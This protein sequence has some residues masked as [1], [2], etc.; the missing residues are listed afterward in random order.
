MKRSPHLW[1]VGCGLALM[2]A[3]LVAPASS[4]SAATN[5]APKPSSTACG[6]KIYKSTGQAWTCTFADDFSGFTLDTKK[7]TTQQTALSGLHGGIECLVNTRNNVAVSGGT[8]QLTVR[9]EAKPF[10][11]KNPYGYYTTQYTSGGVTT[12]G[13]F[14]QAYGRFEF[15]AKISPAQVGGLQTSFWLYPTSSKYGVWPGSGEIDVAETYSNY[16]DRAI[17]YIHYLHSLDADPVTN[18]QCK[19]ANMSSFHTYVAEWTTTGVTISY[20]GVPCLTHRWSALLPLTGSKPFDQ[21]FSIIITQVLG[22]AL[23]TNAFNA[24]TTPLP[25]STVV[26]WVRAWS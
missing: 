7:W 23:S 14:A 6:A 25:A 13:K 4:S 24:T 18:T 22:G 10:T 11:C 8:L 12:T 19:I 21:P 3:V 20:D 16:P 2:A 26:D 17:P 9:K 15:R 1:A 5:T